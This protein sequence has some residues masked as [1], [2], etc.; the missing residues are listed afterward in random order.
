MI[1]FDYIVNSASGEVHRLRQTDTARLAPEALALCRQ[2]REKP[3]LIDHERFGVAVCW[4]DAPGCLSVYDDAACQKPIAIALMLR[5]PDARA[6]QLMHQLLVDVART[7]GVE[8]ATDWLTSITDY[9]AVIT[10]PLPGGTGQAHMVAGDLIQCWAAA[11]FE[12]Q[13]A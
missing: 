13:I 8:P 11:Y 2:A 6:A 1:L 5:E 7:V 12:D 3:E 9:P 4:T 10:A